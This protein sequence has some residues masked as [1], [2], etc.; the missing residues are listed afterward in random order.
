MTRAQLDLR[1]T[2]ANDYMKVEGLPRAL[3][4]NELH[5]SGLEVWCAHRRFKIF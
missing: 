1:F 5:E 3:S 4:R 2:R